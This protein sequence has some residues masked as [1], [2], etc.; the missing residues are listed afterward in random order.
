MNSPVL[1]PGVIFA[2]ESSAMEH[3]VF[4]NV[5]VNHPSRKK[6]SWGSSYKCDGFSS[7]VATGTT[8]PVP[9]CFKDL[10]GDPARPD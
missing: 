7:G 8:S 2:D 9:S 1:V 5:V 10:T 3:I 4:D 6:E